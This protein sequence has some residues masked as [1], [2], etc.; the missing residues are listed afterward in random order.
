MIHSFFNPTADESVVMAQTCAVIVTYGNRV[1]LLAQVVQ[2]V[3]GGNGAE[4]ASFS[5]NQPTDNE[6]ESAGQLNSSRRG[7]GHVV[8]VDNGT[9]PSVAQ[10]LVDLQRHYGDEHFTLVRLPHNTGSAGGFRAGIV[11]AA[12]RADTGHIWVLDDDNKPEPDALSVLARVWRLMGARNDVSLVSYRADKRTYRN[13]VERN[14]P[15][16]IKPNSFF[17]FSV[18]SPWQ[19]HAVPIWQKSGLVCRGMAMAGYGGLWFHK[20]W[21]SLIGE[22][23]ERYYL[24][25]DDYDFTLR[26]TQLQGEIWLCQQSLLQDLEPSWTTEKS[27][28]HHW[29]QTDKGPIRTYFSFRNR[30]ILEQKTTT[31]K[32]LH[33]LNMVLFLLVKVACPNL[34]S[35][36][37]HLRHPAK[38]YDRWKLIFKAIHDG[39]NSV[40]DNSLAEMPSRRKG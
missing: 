8:V 7:V 1:S 30:L 3:L 35:V 18:Q 29:L 39:N 33:T 5:L 28:L 21:L 17:G 23:D 13:L 34:Q 25:F 38:M 31:S 14:K 10:K 27:F 36:C 9:E 37:Y 12:A 40:F 22:P 24:Y 2:G 11:A 15:N 32:V 26:M 16:D 20:N 4:G 6:S 19:K